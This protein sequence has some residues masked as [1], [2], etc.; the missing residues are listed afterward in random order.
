[1]EPP[2]RDRPEGDLPERV[3]DLLERDVLL[4]EHVAHVHPVVVPADAAVPAHAP[5]LAVGGVLERREAGGIRARGGGVAA[6][7]RPL[8]ERL[9]W[10]LVVELGAELSLIHIS[11]PTRLLSISY[12]VF[13]LK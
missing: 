7:R 12:A 8:R 9:V 4:G 1:M 6:R 11:E 10:P 3:V 2:E 13:C 5:H